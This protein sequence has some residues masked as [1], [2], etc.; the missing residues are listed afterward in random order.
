[1][2][3]LLV[4]SC[5]VVLLAIIG[6]SYVN[7]DRSGDGAGMRS[8]DFPSE[9]GLTAAGA[10]P[11]AAPEVPSP[12]S[13]VRFIDVSSQTGITFTYYNG[14]AG[15]KYLVETMGAGAAF[16]DYNNDGYLDI[17]AV[18]GA[19]L[20]GE[21]VN[22]G[23]VLYRNDG[24]GTFTDVTHTAGVGDKAYGMGVCA[25]DYDNLLSQGPL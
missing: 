15:E 7:R 22:P 21:G 14:A 12:S 4:S 3:K 1:M 2:R 24:D 10:E 17:Y 11:A 19:N 5:A 18:N 9:S 20:S 16:F 13:E 25:A 6:L 8:V 23:N